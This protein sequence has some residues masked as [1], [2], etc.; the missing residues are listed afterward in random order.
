MMAMQHG[1]DRYELNDEVEPVHIVP[2]P[3]SI[4]KAA[5][6]PVSITLPCGRVIWVPIE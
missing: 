4:P 2:V 6:R 3:D 5:A 1:H